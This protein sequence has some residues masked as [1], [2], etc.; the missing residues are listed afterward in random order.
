MVVAAVVLVVNACGGDEPASDPPP[1]TADSTTS[2]TTTSTTTS[3]SMP[4]TTTSSTPDELPDTVQTAVDDLASRL[5]VDAATIAVARFEDVTW[6]DGSIG[7]PEP[8]MSYT[9]ALVPGYRIELVVDA[10]SYWYHGARDGSPAYCADP[11]APAPGGS[12]DT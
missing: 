12:G 8:G 1:T 3:T 10:T 9:Q 4:T 2:T 11:T 7:C 6:R 5:G